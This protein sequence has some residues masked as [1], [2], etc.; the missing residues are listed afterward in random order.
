M[1]FL[2]SHEIN[3]ISAEYFS[4]TCWYFSCVFTSTINANCVTNP[5]LFQLLRTAQAPDSRSVSGLPRCSAIVPLCVAA[6]WYTGS[7]NPAVSFVD[8]DCDRQQRVFRRNTLRGSLFI[9]SD[10]FC[11]VF[12]S[13]L[14]GFLLVFLFPLRCCIPPNPPL[15]VACLHLITASCIPGFKRP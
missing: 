10:Y 6:S 7:G 9:L 12:H 4:R 14:L 1:G 2:K 8:E 15:I 13:Q 5:L 11:S 3:G